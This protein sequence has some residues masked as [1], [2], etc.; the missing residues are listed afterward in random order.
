MEDF[1]EVR[2]SL[3]T[4]QIKREQVDE[5]QNSKDSKVDMTSADIEL[6]DN[7]N[8]ADMT[9]ARDSGLKAKNVKD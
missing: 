4:I 9:N 2:K 8:M 3:T 7:N 6:T 1:R 5:S